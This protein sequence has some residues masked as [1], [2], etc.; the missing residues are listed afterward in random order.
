MSL[1]SLADNLKSE[2]EFHT[3]VK[4]ERVIRRT[5]SLQHFSQEMSDIIRSHKHEEAR[6]SNVKAYMTDWFLHKRYPIIH[7]VCNRAIEIVKS[8]TLRDQK[9]TLENF[10]TFDCWGAIY[11][12]HDFTKPHTHG[13]ALWSWCYYIQVPNNAPPLYFREAKLVVNPKPDEIVIFPGHVIHE[14]PHAIDMSDERIV[15][16][17][18]I[19]LDYRNTNYFD[20]MRNFAENN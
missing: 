11:N 13:P 5:L 8:V 9:G 6:K 16:A 18:N 14:V 7:D 10:F 20:V 2:D 12:Q 3:F 1:K 15:L 17:G 19:Y 4:S